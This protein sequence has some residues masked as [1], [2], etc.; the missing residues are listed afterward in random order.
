MN[1]QQLNPSR[2]AGGTSRPVLV[3]TLST[4]P[5]P[6]MAEALQAR[7]RRRLNTPRL[8]VTDTGLRLFRL[9]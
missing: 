8:R 6:A 1:N 5:Q 2:P 9:A 3:P 7:A 4:L